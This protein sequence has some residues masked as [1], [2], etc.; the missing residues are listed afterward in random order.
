MAYIVFLGAGASV[1]AGLPTDKELSK[2]IEEEIRN[3]TVVEGM[4]HPLDAY[5]EI[6]NYLTE[7]RKITTQPFVGLEDIAAF[8][9]IRHEQEIGS[10]Y[11][12]YQGFQVVS[13]E[14]TKGTFKLSTKYQR[15]FLTIQTLVLLFLGTLS[16]KTL[17]KTQYLYPLL[18]ASFRDRTP[19]FTLNLD[20]VVEAACTKTKTPF[21]IG[22]I[23][24]N[25]PAKIHWE[26]NTI[27]LCKLH[28]S[29]DWQLDARFSNRPIKFKLANRFARPPDIGNAFSNAS[30]YGAP[31]KYKYGAPFKQLYRFFDDELD[32]ADKIFVIGYSFRDPHINESL[33]E[34]CMQKTSGKIFVANGKNFSRDDI[35][36]IRLASLT[37]N[38]LR[39]RAEIFPGVASE[40]ISKWF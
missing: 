5:L 16:S 26:E 17:N 20:Y 10:I 11:S 32:K 21:S 34:W 22:L 36:R 7:K 9:Q 31:F 19:I 28:G 38:K 40:A 29:V 23:D 3:I 25:S 24:G 33:V 6:K 1:E 12:P 8:A 15:L 30:I 2:S 4:D 39:E 35:P 27:R 18:E 37:T 13:F 14:G